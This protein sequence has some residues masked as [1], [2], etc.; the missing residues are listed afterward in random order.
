VYHGA[1]ITEIDAAQITHF[2]M[3]I[4]WKAAIHTWKSKGP[5]VHIDLGPYVEGVR[6]FLLG[7]PFPENIVLWVCVVPP[8]VPLLTAL[9]FVPRATSATRAAAYVS[10]RDPGQIR[11]SRFDRCAGECRPKERVSSYFKLLGSGR[12][13]TAG[14]LDYPRSEQLTYIAWRSQARLDLTLTSRPPSGIRAFRRRHKLFEALATHFRHVDG[15]AWQGYVTECGT[16]SPSERPASELP[17]DRRPSVE[18]Q[19]NRVDVCC[20]VGVRFMLSS[21]CV[22]VRD[23]GNYC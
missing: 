16:N 1:A 9:S 23:T 6:R 21:P 13:G 19:S 5:T 10:K 4:F 7:A 11:R 8:S 18:S 20:D 12:T 22:V 15:L 14:S 17:S 2:G 3:G